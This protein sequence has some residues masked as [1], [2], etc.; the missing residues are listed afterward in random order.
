MLIGINQEISPETA[1]KGIKKVFSHRF[2]ESNILKIQLFK[3]FQNI[4]KPVKSKKILKKKL[5]RVIKANNLENGRVL[6]KN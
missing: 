3:P 5:K 2:G 1:E 6:L 4:R